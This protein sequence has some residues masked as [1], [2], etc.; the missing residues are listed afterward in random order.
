[1]NYLK[2][3]LKRIGR[4]IFLIVLFFP[5][6]IFSQKKILKDEKTEQLLPL[7]RI[8]Y[9]L[10]NIIK[11]F[12]YTNE[13][14]EFNVLNEI[15]FDALEFIYLGYENKIISTK[16]IAA[17]DI[18]YLTPTIYQLNEVIVTNNNKP[19]NYGYVLE[20][21]SNEFWVIQGGI[22]G[23]FIENNLPKEQLIKD[24]KFSIGSRVKQDN[25][26]LKLH[27]YKAI[28]GKPKEELNYGN[29]FYKV[30]KGSK[31]ITEIDVENKNITFPKEGI[32]I[33]LE[34]I[35]SDN[36]DISNKKTFHKKECLILDM[37]TNTNR[38][39]FQSGREKGKWYKLEIK[40]INNLDLKFDLMYG[41]NLL[42]IE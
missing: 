12:D 23:V 11:E 40:K 30:K 27:F 8:N 31:G 21:K 36:L 37:F 24:V 9:L 35:Y 6:F 32:C 38:L 17:Q 7:V 42:D 4:T 39:T 13:K 33:G 14:G 15:T 2:T 18:L 20:K 25:F 16:E 22:F 5:I 1:M 10:N 34:L 19:Y 3:K 29:I 41:L 28:D 26:V